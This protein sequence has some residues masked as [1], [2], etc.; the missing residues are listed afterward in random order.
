MSAKITWREYWSICAQAEAKLQ[1]DWNKAIGFEI[2]YER[3]HV[4]LY[5]QLQNYITNCSIDELVE[6]LAG[7]PLQITCLFLHKLPIKKAEK[8]VAGYRID[9]L[10]TLKAAYRNPPQIAAPSPQTGVGG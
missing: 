2:D 10:P 5:P 4:T 8:V 6:F 3:N 9:A 7:A 1:A